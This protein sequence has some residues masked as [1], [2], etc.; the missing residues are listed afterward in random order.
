MSP[1]YGYMRNDAM[2]EKA[3]DTH[4]EIVEQ[5][6]KFPRQ[7]DRELLECLEKYITDK[8]LNFDDTSGAKNKE[9]MHC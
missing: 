6:I 2:I 7:C 3:K 9:S 5:V 4:K 1:D 8:D